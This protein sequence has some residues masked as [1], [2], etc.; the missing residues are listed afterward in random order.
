M[1]ID[2]TSA[3]AG[4]GLVT[5]GLTSGTTA[6]KNFGSRE[7]TAHA[8]QLLLTPEP[9]TN[10]D[11]VIVAAGDVACAPTDSNFNGG[12]GTATACHQTA[13]SNPAMS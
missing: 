1:D 13:T 3:V 9:P 10:G 11:P 4:N 12:A 7:D 5:L 6:G 2:V 8:P